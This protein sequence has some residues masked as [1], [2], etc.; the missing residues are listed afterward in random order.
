M[1]ANS[2]QLVPLYVIQRAAKR[3]AATYSQARAPWGTLWRLE[4]RDSGFN[5]RTGDYFGDVR[6]VEWI[7]FDP[8]GHLV[9]GTN[10]RREA[11]KYLDE[12]RRDPG[13][14]A[15]LWVTQWQEVS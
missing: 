14:H 15:S 12:E 13:F 4:W 7:A 1:A 9:A 10:L 3:R 2:P 6:R 5:R 8:D 11:L